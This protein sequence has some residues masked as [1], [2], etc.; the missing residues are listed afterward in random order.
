[1]SEVIAIMNGQVFDVN[2][3]VFKSDTVYIQDG[4][5][6]SKQDIGPNDVVSQWDMA[7][8]Y[9]AP[10]FIDLHVHVFENHAK[11]GINADKV[12]IEQGVTTIVDAGSTG[13]NDFVKFKE[14]II[15]NSVTEVLTFLNVSSSGLVGGLKELNTLDKLM[16][17][18][19]WEE[20]YKNEQSIV[21][22]K[23]RMSQSIVGDQGIKPLEY[24]RKLAD[25]T[26]VPI[27]VHIGSPPPP[28][29]EILPLLKHGDIVTHAFHGKKGGIL[30]EE[31]NLIKEA[32]DAL[33]RGV[34]LDVGHGTASFS[35]ETIK[36]FKE[37]YEYPFTIST[38]VYDEN[39]EKPVGS[40]MDTMSKLLAIGYSLEQLV[41]SVTIF[42]ATI[43]SLAHH[44]SLKRGSNADITI[45]EIDH[46]PV[47]LYD[48]HGEVMTVTEHLV[49]YATWKN[50]K[51]VFNRE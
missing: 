30:D 29:T 35:Y 11:I 2:K 17:T 25:Q 38:D 41:E 9:V 22:L 7:G 39:F 48:S 12:G 16:E 49:P 40:L 20:I 47:D 44:G 45:F 21:G 19:V 14:D 28:L 36:R 37:K 6:I 43:L 8:K 42:P 46:D 50:G 26:D 27:M 23:A 51:L 24:A 1:M 4:K 15:R 10:G 31:G 3:K 34:K 5:I 32:S 13:S 33:A 18:E